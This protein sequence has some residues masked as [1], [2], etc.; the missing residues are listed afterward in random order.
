VGTDQS[1]CLG[2]RSVDAA[3]QHPI[4]GRHGGH[5]DVVPAA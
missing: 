1:G 5:F 4:A 3:H 2:D